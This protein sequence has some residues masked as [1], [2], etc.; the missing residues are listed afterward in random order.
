MTQAKTSRGLPASMLAALGIVYGDLGT[1]PLY[2]TQAILESS[3]GNVS[4]E[5]ILGVLSLIIWALLLT[6]SVKYGV[7]VMMADNNGEGGILALT[8]LVTGSKE[9]A[10]SSNEPTRRGPMVA[11]LIG[12]GL[13]GGALLYG[14]GILT[15]AISVLSAIEGVKVATPALNHLGIPVA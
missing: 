11:I 8:A 5:S 13:F 6:V 2:R 4:P 15:P 14:D 12:C 10:Q 7:F 9:P 3:G 1:S